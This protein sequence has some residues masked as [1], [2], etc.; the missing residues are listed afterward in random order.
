MNIPI[1]IYTFIL[2]TV[3]TEKTCEGGQL[4]NIKSSSETHGQLG[5]VPLSITQ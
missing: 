1:S 2:T 5:D 4:V 3:I